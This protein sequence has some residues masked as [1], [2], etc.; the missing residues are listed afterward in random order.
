TAGLGT[1][2]GL[3]AGRGGRD[4]GSRS[5]RRGRRRRGARRARRRRRARRHGSRPRARVVDARGVAARGGRRAADPHGAR[6]HRR[7]RRPA[8]ARRRERDPRPRGRSGGRRQARAAAVRAILPRPRGA[9]RVGDRGCRGALRLPRPRG[10]GGDG[11]VTTQPERPVVQVKYV[12]TN[13]GGLW[14]TWRWEH[15][16]TEPRI[17]GIPPHAL[18]GALAA[19][20]QAVPNPRPGESVDDALRRAWDVWGDRGRERRVAGALAAALIPQGL[21]AELN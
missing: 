2:L 5:A 19:F 1:A 13:E 4:R 20:D 8:R 14:V 12:D 3:R 18:A 15:A 21:G 9:H 6:P 11:V 16:L 7:D 10:R 17:W